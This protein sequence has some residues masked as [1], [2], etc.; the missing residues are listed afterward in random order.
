MACLYIH[1]FA[2]LVQV[3]N[4]IWIHHLNWKFGKNDLANQED[5]PH[6]A[7][8]LSK[9]TRDTVPLHTPLEMKENRKEGEGSFHNL[10]HISPEPR[11]SLLNC[12]SYCRQA[13]NIA[14]QG[15]IA[16]ALHKHDSEMPLLPHMVWA[17]TPRIKLKLQTKS[18]AGPRQGSRH[19]ALQRLAGTPWKVNVAPTARNKILKGQ[20]KVP[21]DTPVLTVPS[22]CHAL[23]GQ[24]SEHP[25]S[26]ARTSNCV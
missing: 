17:A 3:I 20:S 5:V 26:A 15:A 18:P 16:P 25:P 14:L 23:Q 22:L 13:K 11:L 10:G 8:T 2:T 1:K 7:G 12:V 24:H 19:T 9:A 4:Q 21:D 6:T